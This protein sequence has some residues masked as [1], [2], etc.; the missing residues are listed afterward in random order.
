[1]NMSVRYVDDPEKLRSWNFDEPA[2]EFFNET[3][4]TA[5]PLS[6]ISG[7]QMKKMLEEWK[8]S[9]LQLFGGKYEDIQDP[10]LKSILNGGVRS[11]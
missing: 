3:Q 4:H 10:V 8:G 7:L 5:V 11:K 9:I 1:M 6:K 2:I